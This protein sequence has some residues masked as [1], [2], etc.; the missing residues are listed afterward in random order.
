MPVALAAFLGGVG[1]G[2]LILYLIGPSL[3][4]DILTGREETA[5]VLD[6]ATLAVAAA[7]IILTLAAAILGERI[8]ANRRALPTVLRVGESS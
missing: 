4:L 8:A 3:G 5:M 2:A 1:A 6:Q 7:G